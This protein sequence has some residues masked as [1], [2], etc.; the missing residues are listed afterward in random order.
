[1]R[2]GWSASAPA[3]ET[4][5]GETASRSLITAAPASEARFG[6]TAAARTAR[7]AVLPISGAEVD[8]AT[9]VALDRR[10]RALEVATRE[11][12]PVRSVSYSTRGNAAAD[13]EIIR[14]V[15]D[16]LAQSESKQQGQLALRIA[17]VIRDFDAQRVEDLK[18]IQ[19]GLRSV[20]ATVSAEA[21]GH[22]ELTNYILTSSTSSAKQK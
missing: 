9:L 2:T 1:V 20:E 3:S 22:R 11:A 15:R 18:R 7:D 13:A 17:Q 14:R 16:M 21:A 8:A 5:F 10:L 12:A 19:Q 4:R 6:G